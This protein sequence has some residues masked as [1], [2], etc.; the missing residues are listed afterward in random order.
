MAGSQ[1][2]SASSS[3]GGRTRRSGV[4]VVV[5]ERLQRAAHGGE[6]E[7]RAGVEGP[8]ALARAAPADEVELAGQL[9]VGDELPAAWSS[10]AS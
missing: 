6:G 7:L 8:G 4:T 9:Q 3:S 5:Y 2:L 10:C 1:T